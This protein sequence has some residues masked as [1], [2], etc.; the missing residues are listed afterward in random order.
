[1]RARAG[2]GART[3]LIGRAKSSASQG[4]LTS[5]ARGIDAG[6][7]KRER[8]LDLDQRAAIRSTLVKSKPPNLGRTP[9]I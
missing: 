3:R 8:R 7:G 2:V 1:V 5:W 9:E 6:E 4:G